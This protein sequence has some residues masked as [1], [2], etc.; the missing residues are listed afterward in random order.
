MSGC[1]FSAEIEKA[2]IEKQGSTL[3]TKV[4]FC[5]IGTLLSSDALDNRP[6]KAKSWGPS[7]LGVKLSTANAPRSWVFRA[8]FR[9]S[10]TS[11]ATR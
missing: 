10:M 5:W 11:P 1:D 2:E 8:I 3:T 9:A 6:A 4:I 7:Y